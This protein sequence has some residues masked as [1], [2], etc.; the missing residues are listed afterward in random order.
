MP[1]ALASRVENKN[2]V[3]GNA[4]KK[5]HTFSAFQCIIYLK[6]T[7]QKY[8]IAADYSI[9]FTPGEALQHSR[10][11]C[12]IN[13]FRPCPDGAR[14]LVTLSNKVAIKPGQPYHWIC[15]PPACP[16]SPF[17]HSLIRL[18]K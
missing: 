6:Q 7:A 17:Q 10:Q 13:Y 4:Q 11:M 16:S 5:S 15:C 9:L 8:G 18:N 12:E 1:R 3:T 14:D 2:K